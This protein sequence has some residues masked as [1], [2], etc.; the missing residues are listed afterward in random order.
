[1][2]IG[3]MHAHKYL[4]YITFLNVVVALA[5]A[6]AAS[7]G[8][9]ARIALVERIFRLGV[10]MPGRLNVALGL[11]TLAVMA[12]QASGAWTRWGLWAGLVLWGPLEV[13]GKRWILAG[14]QSSPAQVGRM[15]GGLVAIALGL[16]AIIGLMTM[17]RLGRL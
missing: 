4:G 14:A 10:L 16:T 13:L 2:L 8:A 3:L 17:S 5:I 11:V 9:P 7:V 15:R 12:S 6:L 1:M